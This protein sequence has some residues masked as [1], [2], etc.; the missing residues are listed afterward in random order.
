[1]RSAL[2]EAGS[3]WKTFAGTGILS[4]LLT[5]VIGVV[6]C[7]IGFIVL[8][9]LWTLV[10]PVVMMENSKGRAALKRS[11]DLVKRS[12]AT[13]TAAVALTFLIP[14]VSAGI[15]S[16]T[17]NMTAKAVVDESGKV[18]QIVEKA[19]VD[20]ES[21]E[22]ASG[23]EEQTK[24]GSINYRIGQGMTRVDLA[25]EKGMRARVT[26]T[27]RESLL[28]LLLLPLQILVTSFTAI[29][30]ALLYLKTRQAGG[31]S[32]QDLLAK[33]EETDQPRKKWQER[34][35]Q[36]LIQSGRLTTATTSKP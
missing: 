27:M 34:V 23:Q 25:G 13:S 20:S 21:T 3:K 24:E 33:F 22:P 15:I 16:F 36:R 12:L 19:S 26:D 17:V 32:L 28:H 18:Q 29:I 31:E 2:K 35:R 1:M 5:L 10:A 4:F 6:T 30:I 9:I 11:K 8:N 14:A 7:G